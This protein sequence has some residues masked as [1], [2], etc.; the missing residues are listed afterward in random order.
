MFSA[1]T[2]IFTFSILWIIYYIREW[3]AVWRH[4]PP[5]PYG[6]PLLGYLPFINIKK[7]VKT[8]TELKERY[9]PIFSVTMTHG[10]YNIHLCDP[11]I[12]ADAFSR[13]EFLP[14]PD[15]FMFKVPFGGGGLLGNNGQIWQDNR[16]FTLRT[17]RDSGFGK[18]SLNDTATEDVLEV[19]RIFKEKL[20]KPIDVGWDLNIAIIRTLWRIVSGIEWGHDD[21]RIHKLFGMVN[22]ALE[23]AGEVSLGNFHSGLIRFVPGA[24]EGYRKIMSLIN[25]SDALF[26]GEIDIHKHEVGFGDYIDRYLEEIKKNGSDHPSFNER[27][28]RLN[29]R[30]LFGAG[31]E[32]TSTTIRWAL[33]FLIENPD[34]QAKAQEEIDRVLGDKQPHL[35]DKPNLPYLEA[36]I[37]EVNR[38]C[39]VLPLG[40][41]HAVREDVWFR[42]YLFPAGSW[43]FGNQELVHKDPKFFPDPEKFDPQRFLDE[44][45]QLRKSVPGYM[46][47]GAGKRQCLGE[48]LAKLQLFLYLATLLQTFKF[49]K[50][51]KIFHS[52]IDVSPTFGLI[53]HP[54]PFSL[55]IHE[56]TKNESDC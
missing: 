33:H 50:P 18:T 55:I 16:R 43:V 17:L 26:Q 21:P 27:E 11:D 5:G 44:E 30:S 56:R 51:K 15:S 41:F 29:I 8:F 47:F 42:G 28:L 22:D 32:T 39:N 3:W 52:Y 25:E 1:I 9:G 23:G 38:M 24:K 35:D 12:I 4:M 48:S 7:Q 46:P 45:G 10:V 53:N 54:P 19:V 34:I 31:S 36:V 2:L 40:V 14:R 6:L 37:R 20:G 49:S 13:P